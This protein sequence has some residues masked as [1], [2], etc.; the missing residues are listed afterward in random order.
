[1]RSVIDLGASLE[2]NF[3]PLVTALGE[4]R[5]PALPGARVAAGAGGN[6]ALACDLAIAALGHLC[7]ILRAHRARPTPVAAGNWCG[8]GHDAR[9][10]WR[11]WA[12]LSA[13][14]AADWGLMA[15]RRG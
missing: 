11:C 13:T 12:K 4:R 8:G 10:G 7:A 14:Q 3:N 9:W 1:L 6:L 15:V 2:N 5:I